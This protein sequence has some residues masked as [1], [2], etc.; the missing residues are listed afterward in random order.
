[1]EIGPAQKVGFLKICELKFAWQKYARV[2]DGIYWMM[3][4]KLPSILRDNR[5]ERCHYIC[6]A[7][8]NLRL[9]TDSKQ[10]GIEVVLAK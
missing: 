7:T 2:T 1:M 8:L 3:D 10:E 4:C 5:F 6:S 9:H